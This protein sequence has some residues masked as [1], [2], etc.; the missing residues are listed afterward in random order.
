M[1]FL[2][3]DLCLNFKVLIENMSNQMFLITYN[4][5]NEK[6]FINA[7]ELGYIKIIKYFLKKDIELSVFYNFALIWACKRGY[8]KILKLL[9]KDK[10]IDP[11]IY[12]NYS[13]KEACVNGWLK[14]VKLLLKDKR[15]N[16]NNCIN[17]LIKI[18]SKHN[19]YK[20][21]KVLKKYINKN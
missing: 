5:K 20:I 21:I 15:I 3:K 6:L 11:N 17:D 8:Y 10:R 9:L 19:Y 1:F 18:A 12:Y 13:I 14:L 2:Y 4:G 7:Y 16:L